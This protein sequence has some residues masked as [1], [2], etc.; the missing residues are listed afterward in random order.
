M[1]QSGVLF[2]TQK[3]DKAI[4]LV[5]YAK[6]LYEQQDEWLKAA[7]PLPKPLRARPA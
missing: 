6:C 4:P 3:K 2:Q 7:F 1:P 5:N